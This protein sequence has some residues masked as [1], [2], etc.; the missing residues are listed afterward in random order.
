M[1]LRA[2]VKKYSFGGFDSEIWKG[3]DHL[4]HFCCYVTVSPEINK[5]LYDALCIEPKDGRYAYSENKV[6]EDLPANG[7]VT[8]YERGSY[9]GADGKD[10]PYVKFGWDYAH[11]W[12]M[13]FTASGMTDRT[14]ESQVYHD[15][16]EVIAILKNPE[17]TKENV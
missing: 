2:T 15:L 16:A 12:D 14:T 8:Y 6:L 3:E 13:E 9:H 4:K 10:Y 7:G 17:L 11:S 5:G 1:S